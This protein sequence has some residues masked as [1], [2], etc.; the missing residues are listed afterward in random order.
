ML[1]RHRRLWLLNFAR[2]AF[3]A[4]AV[5]SPACFPAF[6]C[7]YGSLSFHCLRRAFALHSSSVWAL[8]PG[9]SLVLACVRTPCE[10]SADIHN[11]VETSFLIPSNR[12]SGST[13]SISSRL[14]ALSLSYCLPR[15][16]FHPGT[17]IKQ[18]SVTYPNARCDSK[19]EIRMH[20]YGRCNESAA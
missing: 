12:S 3:L 16:S 17:Q 1:R 9:G 7:H 10:Q 2:R 13:A 19:Q 14:L 18:T 5:F 8:C 11:F 20:C 6:S 15:S 4:R